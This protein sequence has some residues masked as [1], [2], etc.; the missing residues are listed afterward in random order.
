MYEL[1]F[2]SKTIKCNTIQDWHQKV[3]NL[4]KQG[5]MYKSFKKVGTKYRF[6]YA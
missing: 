5:F 4:E 3:I 1:I 2:K 6:Y